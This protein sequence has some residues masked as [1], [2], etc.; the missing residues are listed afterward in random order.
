MD[1]D[2]VRYSRQVMLP[3]FGAVGQARLAG[4]S[5]L[6]VGA[7]GLGNPVL[8][9]LAG[10]GVGRIGIIDGDTV[11][12]HNL[13]RQVIFTDA[14]IGA[15]KAECAARAIEA[16]APACR[17]DVYPRALTPENG[18]PIIQLYDLIVDGTDNFATRYLVNDLCVELQKPWVSGAVH[19][20]TGQVTVFNAL[21]RG[22]RRGPTYRCLFPEPPAPGRV[23]GCGESGVLGVLPGVIGTVMATEALKLMSG[24]GDV[25]SGRLWLFDA[26]G[27]TTRT[28]EFQRDDGAVSATRVRTA[29]EY[30]ELCGGVFCTEQKGGTMKEIGPKELKA[31]LDAG[32]NITLIDVREPFERDIASIGGASI[33]LADVLNRADEIPRN[34]P[35]V[36]YCRSGGRSGQACAQLRQH[37]NFTN[38]INLA[39]GI[40][41]WSDEVDSTVRKY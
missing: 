2:V 37:L 28:V 38:L 29:A 7:G 9:Y 26:L 33:P 8:L 35:V 11:E 17:V 15:S 21:D 20:F 24:V 3:E 5:V 41:R 14:D 34:N 1:Y 19:R 32:E 6:V 4:G 27:L 13:H 40:L 12:K 16:R 30:R 39:G 22:G 31:R 10:A 18:A 36:I 23:P 25:L